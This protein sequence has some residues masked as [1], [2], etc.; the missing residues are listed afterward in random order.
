MLV[1]S[2]YCFDIPAALKT[3]IDDFMGDPAEYETYFSLLYT[4]YSVPNVI[5]PFFAGYFVDKVGVRLSMLIFASLVG[6]GQVIFSFGLLL[7]SWPV[8]FLGRFVF[9]LGGENLVVANSAL[10]ADWFKGQE[11]AFAFGINLS[12]ARLGSVFNNLL[13]PALTNSLG[14]VFACWFGAF[15]CGLSILCVVVTIPIDKAF[16]IKLE[17]LRKPLLENMEQDSDTSLNHASTY[18][19]NTMISIDESRETSNDNPL[20]KNASFTSHTQETSSVPINDHPQS[21]YQSCLTSSRQFAKETISLPHI[22]WVLVILCVVVYGC[23]LPFN[24]IESSLLLERDY[25]KS[26]PS[27]CALTY[28]GLC[29]SDTNPPNSYCPSSKWYQPPL[30]YNVTLSDGS[31]YPGQV[32]YDDVDCTEDVWSDGCT[33]EFCNRLSTSESQAAV[34]MSIP[35][36]I[37]AVMSPILGFAVDKVGLRAIIASIAPMLL[38]VVHSLLGLTKVSPVGP[39]VGQGLAYTG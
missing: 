31:K 9:G 33:I 2:Y 1:G 30:P 39:L 8:M 20:W 18:K 15:L 37:S 26:P 36:I 34:I 25:F 28:S 32:Q 23:V 17:K 35:Y 3:Q 13:S 10:L 29:Q 27:D 6:A 38:V 7:E 5:L 12:I 16:D 4:L 21:C 19:H 24:N 14:L 11:L 22:F